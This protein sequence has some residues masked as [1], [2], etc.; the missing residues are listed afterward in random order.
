MGLPE[1]IYASEG[2]AYLHLP[3]V[4]VAESSAGETRYLLS[5][6]L[7]SVRQA[8]DDSGAVVA[9]NEFDPYG[10]PVQSGSEPYGFTGEWWDSYI[11]LLHLRARWYLAETGTF[12]SRDPWDGDTLLP[13]TLNGWG[14]VEG[15]PVNRVDPAGLSSEPRIPTQLEWT[16]AG[17]LWWEYSHQAIDR[18]IYY[19]KDIVA[20]AQRHGFM[21]LLICTAN[22]QQGEFLYTL[23]SIVYRESLGY[24]QEVS[25]FEGTLQE[26]LASGALPVPGNLPSIGI[27][28]MRSNTALELERAGYILDSGENWFNIN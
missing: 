8:V 15:N 27:G 10:N 11:K 4:I 5:D 6:G 14:Y 1:V 19:R 12:L 3:G 24:D 22:P 21:P 7:G 20:A 28:Q 9:Y 13:Q 18:L 2:N 16:Q 26:Y 25:T 17:G 23:A